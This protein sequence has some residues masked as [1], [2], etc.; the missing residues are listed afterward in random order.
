LIFICVLVNLRIP[1][2]NLKQRKETQMQNGKLNNSQRTA[3]VKLVQNAYSRRIEEQRKLYENAVAEITKEVKAELGVAKM[4]SELKDLERR[5]KQLE[6]KKE[7]LGFS[8]YND[9]LLPGSEAQKM[10]NEGASAEKSEITALEAQMDRTVSAVWTATELSEVKQM[11]DEL[12]A[13]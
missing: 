8:K 11:V 10:V 5:T 2:S 9:H 12:L 6:A 1:N 4:D 7:Q 3:L 13:D